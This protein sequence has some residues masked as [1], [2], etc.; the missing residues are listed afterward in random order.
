MSQHCVTFSRYLEQV[1]K[2][3]QFPGLETLPLHIM[4][5]HECL[6]FET[7]SLGFCIRSNG[8]KV[9]NV[10]RFG[11][12]ENSRAVVGEHLDKFDGDIALPVGSFCWE[13]F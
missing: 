2:Y 11:R 1:E 8:G 6:D 3:L 9:V 10:E 7:H 5:R 4:E 13:V 12:D